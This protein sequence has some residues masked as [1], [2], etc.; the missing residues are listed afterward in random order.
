[1]LWEGVGSAISVVMEFILI[2]CHSIY[3]STGF[4]AF[5]PPCSATIFMYVLR[6]AER[7]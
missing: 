5:S 2:P 7:G 6:A 4:A 3:P 1:M